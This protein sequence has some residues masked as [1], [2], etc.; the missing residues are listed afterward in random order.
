MRSERE[1]A[2]TAHNPRCPKCD[3]RMEEG[4]ILDK[5]HGTQLPSQWV[6]GEPEKSFWFGTKTAGKEIIR[7]RTYRC[8]KCGY[9][10]SYAPG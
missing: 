4:F 10:E 6:G 3:T 1:R 7:V 9:L 5:A 8:R 2:I